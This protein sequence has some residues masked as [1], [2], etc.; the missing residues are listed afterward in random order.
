MTFPSPHSL[1]GVN[2][3]VHTVAFVYVPWFNLQYVLD[4]KTTMPY[5]HGNHLFGDTHLFA[6]DCDDSRSHICALGTG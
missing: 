1:D 2:P 6:L 4:D 5:V 3:R